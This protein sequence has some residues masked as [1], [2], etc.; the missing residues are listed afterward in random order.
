MAGIAITEGK[1]VYKDP[2]DGKIKL[3]DADLSQ[4]AAEGIGVAVSSASG[5]DQPVEYAIDGDLTFNAGLTAGTVYVVSATAGGIA[6]T[7]DMD[8]ASTW[9]C[10]I[11][12]VASSTTNMKLAIKPSRAI[13]A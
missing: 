13:N 6:P 4:A 10:T 11:I 2:T 12:G 1:S 7:A 9:Y 3:A 8:T 5:V